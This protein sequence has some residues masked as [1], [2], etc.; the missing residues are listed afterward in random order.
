MPTQA[1]KPAKAKDSKTA[2][3]SAA[4][5]S[6]LAPAVDAAKM[7][8]AAAM[9]KVLAHPKRMAIVDLLGREEKLTVT[10]IYTELDMPQA[11]ASQHLI[12]LKDRGV[13]TSEKAGTKIYYSL[14][15]PHLTEVIRC[16][17]ENIAKM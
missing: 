14:L 8:R 4:K 3:P 13:L 9:L 5:K 15:V 11:I 7:E 12:T 17:E 10:K 16:L 2:A 1:P 6:I